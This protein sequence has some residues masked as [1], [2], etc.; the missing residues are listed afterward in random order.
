MRTSLG[1]LAWRLRGS[2]DL[3]QLRA[4]IDR[5]LRTSRYLGYRESGGWG[6]RQGPSFGL[7]G[8]P[9]RHLVLD[10]T[11]DFNACLNEKSWSTMS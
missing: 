10:P 1:R 3:S 9:L 11:R 4:K 8:S 2:G 5:G 7:D 6:C